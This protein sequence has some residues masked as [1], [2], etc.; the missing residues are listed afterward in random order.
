MSIVE[1]ERAATAP[2]RWIALS[3][4]KKR[5]KDGV[6]PSRITQPLEN[7]HCSRQLYLVPGGRY[8]VACD[9]SYIGVWDLGF[10]SDKDPLLQTTKVWVTAADHI[11]GFLVNPTPDGLG[12]RILTYSYVH[13]P[14]LRHAFGI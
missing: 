8:L 7:L 1:L 9:W 12:I 10:V 5:N 2:R 11:V 3:S 6:L 4:S 14:H 13:N